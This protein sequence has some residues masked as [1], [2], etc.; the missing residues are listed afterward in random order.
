MCG[1]G[2]TD[3]GGGR[4]G[5]RVE[6][7]ELFNGNSPQKAFDRDYLVGGGFSHIDREHRTQI[8]F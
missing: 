8:L 6:A 1:G 5:A 2:C 3:L 7:E 4:P